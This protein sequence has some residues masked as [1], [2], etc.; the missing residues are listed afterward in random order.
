MEKVINSLKIIGL[1]LLA[2]AFVFASASL[3]HAQELSVVE[4]KRNITLSDDDVVYKD[5]YINGGDGTALRKNM[6]VNVKRKITVKDSGTKTIGDF[7]TVVGQLKVIHIGNKISVAREF[8]LTPRDAEP[9]LEQTGIMIGDRVDL[10]KSYID[11]T[12][13]SSRRKTSEADPAETK[14]TTELKK[15]DATALNNA[16]PAS[17]TATVAPQTAAAPT[18]P[19]APVATDINARNPASVPAAQSEEPS[20][21]QKVMPISPSAPALV[22]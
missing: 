17:P 12:K 16:Q 3:A 9:M 18:A 2:L 1:H 20:L 15:E 19:A 8:K 7:E 11:N 13:P 10:E 5:F 14:P 21:F 6:V 4:V 22:D